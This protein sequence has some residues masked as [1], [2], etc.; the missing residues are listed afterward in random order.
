MAVRSRAIPIPVRV[1]V[2]VLV[3]LLAG[4]LIAGMAPA[5][6]A[7]QAAPDTAEAIGALADY[8]AA[9]E[10]DGGKVWGRSTCGPMVLVDRSTRMAVA[11]EAPPVDG[12]TRHGAVWLGRLPDALYP[13]NT[14]FDWQGHEWAMAVLPLGRT[15]FGR[16]Q[17]V[18]HEAFHRIQDDAGITVRDVSSPHLDERDGRYWLRLELQALAAALEATGDGNRAGA[19]DAARAATRDALLFRAARYQTYPG[20][21]TLEAALELAEGMA[22]YTG[23]RIA[24]DYLGGTATEAA[25]RA[26]AF[27]KRPTYARALGYGT[28]PALGLL[29]DR[30]AAGWQRSVAARPLARRLAEAVA[31]S[32]PSDAVGEAALRAPLYGGGEI[33]SQE[34]ARASERAARI[35]DYQRRLANGPVL[36]LRQEKLMRGFDPNTLVPFPGGATVYP[37]GHFTA[38]WGTLTVESGGALVAAD[39]REVR[40]EAPNESA[41]STIKG[42]GWVLTLAEGWRL[43]HDSTGQL[44]AAR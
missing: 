17:L 25:A 12:F 7:Q 22:E 1:P 18:V 9:C 36:V 15:R 2:P 16:L 43:A 33:A 23:A 39:Y 4:G 34:D 5:A 21:D 14:S 8:A 40:V 24:G 11:N 31:F 32:A 35:A 3:G 10:A 38:D 26:R 28:G 30:W 41:G 29:L 20:A 42:P 19:R 37:T 6:G 13:T 44:T 27:E